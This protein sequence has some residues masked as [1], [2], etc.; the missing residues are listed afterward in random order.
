MVATTIIR[1]QSLTEEVHAR[2]R[3]DLLACRLA[4]GSKLSI[5]ELCAAHGVSLAVVREALSRLSAEGLVVAEAQRGFR[6][7]PIASRD[8]A[9]LTEARIEIE[10]SCLTRS[11]ASGG[12]DWETRVTS[13]YKRM[14]TLP[15]RDPDD[16]ARLGDAY[17]AA[18]ARFHAEL[19]SGCEN[20]W[21]LKQRDML[22]VQSER[23]R[24][25]SV[26]LQNPVRDLEAE[27]RA[28]MHA[29]LDRAVERAC[30]AMRQHLSRTTK[31]L[32]A[33]GVCDLS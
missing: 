15:E 13:A 12:L 27:H 26:P 17:A 11:I 14:A 23:Y 2:L 5:N 16:P 19:V 4:P 22:F 7:P 33:S 10:C 32:L 24:R 8:L 20:P 1:P 3:A 6:V 31:I 29:T 21:F 28:L 25:L 18:H 30:L 9:H